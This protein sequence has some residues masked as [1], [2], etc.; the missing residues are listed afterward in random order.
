MA[1]TETI[2]QILLDDGKITPEQ[3]SDALSKQSAVPDLKLGRLLVELGVDE[4]FITQALAVQAGLDFMKLGDRI[5]PT[6]FSYQV[7]VEFARKH[8]IVTVEEH[9]NCFRIAI[10]DPRNLGV[11]DNIR[12][13]LN[14]PIEP[15][16]VSTSDMEIALDRVYGRT[17]I[18][19]R[20]VDRRQPTTK[21]HSAHSSDIV[22]DSDSPEE[23]P[24]AVR[25]LD[26]LLD[27]AVN[28]GA[29]DI[30]I[31]P[32]QARNGEDSVLRVR[33]R[34]DGVLHKVGI[35]AVTP[36]ALA[37]RCKIIADLDTAERRRPQDGRFRAQ[38]ADRPLD[39]RV[40]TVPT[41]FGEKV[42]L[43]LLDRNRAL[44]DLEALG[45][46]GK[47]LYGFREAINKP[48]GLLLVTGPTGSGKTTTLY[49]A[50]SERNDDGINLTTIED[51]IEYDLYGVNQMQ[52]HP[53]IGLTFAAGLRHILRQDPDIVLVGEIRDPETTEVAMQAALTG[54]LVMSTLHTNDAIGAIARLT[55][56]N[57]EPFL[58]AD[59]LVGV[60]SQRL[61]RK[62]CTDCST[63]RQVT[64]TEAERFGLNVQ[65]E[66][67]SPQGCSSCLGTG[68]RGR[69]EI[70]E[71][72]ELTENVRAKIRAG[73]S[74]EEIS[75]LVKSLGH[76][77]LLQNALQ[78][79]LSGHTSL[80]EIGRVA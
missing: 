11:F 31:E 41:P 51:P 13:F 70:Y 19:R 80:E 60:L 54:H 47:Y 39:V 17:A 68:Y 65:S 71:L 64:E 46:S 62:L 53:K 38:V 26:Q 52:V 67:H 45:M 4:D 23:D 34:I 40:S 35:D 37:A 63:I 59:A 30:H 42:V 79:V 16:L 56:L 9:D 69:V 49:A 22:N 15:V 12:G 61:V 32:F 27:R 77:T 75:T 3:L 7:P 29:S 55:D 10:T 78:K 44:L 8:R 58:V 1:A 66:I 57:A 25:V 28:D 20:A 72:L 21:Y 48:H 24:I 43:R 73:R 6:D 74:S 18:D 14:K 33:L 50:L 76:Q 2:G 5:L 36:R